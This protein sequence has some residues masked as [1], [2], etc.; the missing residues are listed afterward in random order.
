MQIDILRKELMLYI[1]VGVSVTA[2]DWVVFVIS[3]N[4]LNI[5]YQ[6]SLVLACAAGSAAHYIANKSL[7]FKCHSSRIT[8]QLS[9]YLIVAAGSIG[10]SMLI[11]HILV[12]LFITNVII[13]RFATTIIMILPNYLLH[14]HITFSK[15]IFAQQKI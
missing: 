12:W 6:L 15:H 13:L 3:V 5:H 9:L 10:L 14:K 7:T 8:T 4:M 1:I 2:L 11:L